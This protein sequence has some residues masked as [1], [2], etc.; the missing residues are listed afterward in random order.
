MWG[1]AVPGNGAFR[2]VPL[3]SLPLVAH[4]HAWWLT[5]L[6]ANSF[7][8]GWR[9]SGDRPGGGFCEDRVFRFASGP[10]FKLGQEFLLAAIAHRDG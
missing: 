7:H 1:L 6:T 10:G 3:G 2:R 9:Q 5:V 4:S 8:S